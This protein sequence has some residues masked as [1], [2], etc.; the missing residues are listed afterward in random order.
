MHALRDRQVED[1][2]DNQPYK[3]DPAIDYTLP[4]H[5]EANAIP[6]VML[7][8]RQDKID[9]ENSVQRWSELIAQCWLSMA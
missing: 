6:C 9:Q 2:G 5:C 7:E 8:V 4:V 1:V 3:V